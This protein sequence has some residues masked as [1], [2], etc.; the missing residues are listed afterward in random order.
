MELGSKIVNTVN[1]M[2]IHHTDFSFP[3]MENPCW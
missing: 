3:G 2:L 1:E